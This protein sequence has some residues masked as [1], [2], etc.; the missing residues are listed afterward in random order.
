MGLEKVRKIVNVSRLGLIC[1]FEEPMA[2][3]G[4]G[5]LFNFSYFPPSP[6]SDFTEVTVLILTPDF[7]MDLSRRSII[8]VLWENVEN[9]RRFILFGLPKVKRK[10]V[11]IEIKKKF[12]FI[13][14][15]FQ[16]RGDL[17][18]LTKW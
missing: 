12:P 10:G 8:S 15:G 13:F 2:V 4:A 16:A 1:Y 11:R 18:T 3:A 7:S 17:L 9:L 6:L 14:G 5:N